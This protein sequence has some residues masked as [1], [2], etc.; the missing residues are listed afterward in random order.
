MMLLQ[1]IEQSSKDFVF[2]RRSLFSLLWN[3]L[4]WRGKNA[5][6]KINKGTPKVTL[7]QHYYSLSLFFSQFFSCLVLFAHFVEILFNINSHRQSHS[8]NFVLCVCGLVK[9]EEFR[10]DEQTD[11][12][13]QNPPSH[14]FRWETERQGV[15]GRA[16][17]TS[18]L[19]NMRTVLHG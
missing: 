11:M 8:M 17:R 15:G 1:H 2:L 12:A 3:I 18:C 16:E 13:I 14:S 7:R 10:G 19:W 6:S 4:L 9:S 5:E